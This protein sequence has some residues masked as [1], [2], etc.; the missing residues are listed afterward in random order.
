MRI[1]VIIWFLL[2]M[3]VLVS[4]ETGSQPSDAASQ[5]RL[6]LAYLEGEGVAI[7]EAR[8]ANLFR[9]AAEQGDADGQFNLG[10][11]HIRGSG[12]GKDDVEAYKWLTLAH[13]RGRSDA[14]AVRDSIAGRM[15]PGQL[16]KARRLA[17]GWRPASAPR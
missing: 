2:F 5:V 15:T 9:Q 14:L 10:L 13:E 4:A 6:G 11:L 7:D 16:N 8:A 3:P 12:V 17:S 1:F